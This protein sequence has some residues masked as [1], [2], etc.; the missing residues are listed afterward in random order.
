VYLLAVW[1][2]HVRPNENP[3]IRGTL[4]P[5][6]AAA[7]LVMTFSGHAVITTGVVLAVVVAIAVVLGSRSLGEVVVEKDSPPNLPPS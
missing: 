2:L 7:V 6:G 5:I 1:F 3:P 4:L